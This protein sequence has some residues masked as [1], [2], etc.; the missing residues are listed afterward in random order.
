[1]GVG[2]RELSQLFRKSAANASLSQ[3]IISTPRI[4]LPRQVA[5]P[6]LRRA[7]G[8]APVIQIESLL[9]ILLKIA[10]GTAN[11]QGID[12]AFEV[13]AR[14]Q[15][16]EWHESVARRFRAGIQIESGT[17]AVVG[18]DRSDWQGKGV[19]DF[20]EAAPSQQT[21]TRNVSGFLQVQ[22]DSVADAC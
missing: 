8:Q 3:G 14:L 6:I 5:S 12:A 7:Q 18:Q 19:E 10:A 17:R 13:E 21:F 20:A 11:K 1:A 15:N 16:A 2:S 22:R 9:Q 4:Q